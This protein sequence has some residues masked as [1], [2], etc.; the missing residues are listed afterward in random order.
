MS[1]VQCVCKK[2]GQKFIS[3]KTRL[4]ENNKYKP[5]FCS[6]KCYGNF[7]TLTVEERKKRKKIRNKEYQKKYKLMIKNRNFSYKKKETFYKVEDFNFSNL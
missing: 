7:R 5:K 6:I 2:C 4:R 3:R 1:T